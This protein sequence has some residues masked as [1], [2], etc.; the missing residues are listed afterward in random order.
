MAGPERADPPATSNR[1]RSSPRTRGPGLAFLD[2]ARTVH[3]SDLSDRIIMTIMI[4]GISVPLIGWVAGAYVGLLPPWY[5]E[6]VLP[7]VFVVA[8]VAIAIVAWKALDR[9]D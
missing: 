9:L 8:V 6:I 3:V 2:G 4:L 1:S 7:A 5:S